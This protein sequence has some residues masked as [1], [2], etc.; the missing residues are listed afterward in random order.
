M[1]I[2]NILMK[3]DAKKVISIGSAIAMGIVAVKN[4]LDDQKKAAEFDEMKKTLAEL[5]KGKES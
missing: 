1:D 3:V 5:T 4:S 2:K